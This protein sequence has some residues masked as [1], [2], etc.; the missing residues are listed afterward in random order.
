[1]MENGAAFPD[2]VSRVQGKAAVFDRERTGFLIDHVIAT[3]Q[4]RR[5]GANVVGY[6]VWSLL[7][8]FEWAAGYGP[9]F[10]IVHVDY[11]TLERTPKLS[12]HWFSRLCTTRTIPTL[13]SAPSDEAPE[14]RAW[15][16]RADDPSFASSDQGQGARGR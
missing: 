6:L 4:A 12:S 9:R 16:V 10:G 8:N 14:L 7:D 1:V 3:H 13:R 11:D 2:T 15:P 5:R